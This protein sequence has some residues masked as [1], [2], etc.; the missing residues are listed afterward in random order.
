MIVKPSAGRLR[1]SVTDSEAMVLELARLELEGPLIRSLD[2]RSLRAVCS[3]CVGAPIKCDTCLGVGWL[4][5]GVAEAESVCLD[6]LSTN[7]KAK[8]TRGFL[9]H[10]NYDLNR[11]T[12]SWHGTRGRCRTTRAVAIFWAAAEFALQ[13]NPIQE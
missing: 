2:S 7:P 4:P 11:W 1:D 10:Y 3:S 6:W 13:F 12:F 5:V 8:R 9:L